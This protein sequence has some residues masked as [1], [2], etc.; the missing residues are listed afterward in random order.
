VVVPNTDQANRHHPRPV[1]PGEPPSA[2]RVPS[3]CPFHP[4]CPEA[5]P[6][7]CDAAFPAVT[8]FGDGHDVACHLYPPDDA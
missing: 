4:R 8:R 7:T 3:G 6:G 5:M 2:L 1:I